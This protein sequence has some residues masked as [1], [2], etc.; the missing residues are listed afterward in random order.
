MIT[1]RSFIKSIIALAAG[2]S[3]P[4]LLKPALESVENLVEAPSTGRVALMAADAQWHHISIVKDNNVVK[5]F[6]DHQEVDSI[7]GCDLEVKTSSLNLKVGK[8]S[9]PLNVCSRNL[10]KDFTFSLWVTNRDN[11]YVSDL[12]L[13]S[14]A[15]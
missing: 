8:Y 7:K 3:V 2:T 11:G 12:K 1:R 14:E 10:Q 5:L 4:S 6:F 13:V 9:E 15:A